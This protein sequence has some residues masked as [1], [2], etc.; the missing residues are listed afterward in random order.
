MKLDTK[1]METAA[2]AI[3]ENYYGKGTW[4][5]AEPS[6]RGHARQAVRLV[7]AA[8]EKQGLSVASQKEPAARPAASATRAAP[9]TSARP[10]QRPGR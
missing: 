1:P 7:L 3:H 6:E 9:T 2:R 4:K 5:T 8:L 10:P